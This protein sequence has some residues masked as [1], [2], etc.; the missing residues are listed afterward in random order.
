[1]HIHAAELNGSVVFALANA[2]DKGTITDKSFAELP[3][4]TPKIPGK[5]T[6]RAILRAGDATSA[7]PFA[8]GWQT[9]GWEWAV[10]VVQIAWTLVKK[11]AWNILQLR[12]LQ[13]SRTCSICITI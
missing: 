8:S 13:V 12:C 3:K 6:V 2:L 9:Q 5:A 4:A 7:S 11:G 1:M 10:Y